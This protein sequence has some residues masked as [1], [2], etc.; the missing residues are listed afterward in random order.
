MPALLGAS[1]H[2]WC[3]G[4]LHVPTLCILCRVVSSRVTKPAVRPCNQISFFKSTQSWPNLALSGSVGSPDCLKLTHLLC[5]GPQA[6]LA[7]ALPQPG[8]PNSMSWL[9]AR[10]ELR[11][12]YNSVAG[13][14]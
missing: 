14:L 13:Y 12:R 5:H 6:S 4:K 7:L 9:E 2:G 10:S 3:L 8:F 1:L 11:R